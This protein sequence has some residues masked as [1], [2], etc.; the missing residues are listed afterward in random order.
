MPV[1]CVPLAVL[2]GREHVPFRRLDTRVLHIYVASCRRESP[3]RHARPLHEQVRA[4]KKCRSEDHLKRPVVPY[5]T[6]SLDRHT[7][8]R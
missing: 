4:Y 7:L 5:V 2:L 8:L 3:T 1:A 6:L